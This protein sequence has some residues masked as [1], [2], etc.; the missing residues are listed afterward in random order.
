MFTLTINGI[1]VKAEEGMTV[2]EAADEAG[3]Y[4]PTLCH[5]EDLSTFG[6]CR[7]CM[8]EADDRLVTACRAPVEDGMVVR[9]D[10]PQIRQIRLNNVELILANHNEDCQT[11]DRSSNCQLQKVAAF[12]GVTSDR[13]KD[14]RRFVTDEPVDDSNPFFYRDH[15]K[16]I[17]CGVCIRTCEEINGIAALDF[18][19][20]GYGTSVSVLGDK[21][22]HESNCESCGECVER[23]PT[24]ALNATEQ[25]IPE[26]EVD[27]VCPYCGVGCGITVGVRGEEVVSVRGTRDNPV[28]S[29]ELC[30][31]GRYGFG[32]INHPDRLRSPLIKKDGEFEEVSWDE[33]LDLVASKLDGYKEKYGADSLAGISSARCTNEE[34][35]LFQKL[36]RAV[37][38]NNVDH[39]ARLCHAP[40]VAGL[41]STFGSG[42]MT[43]SIADIEEAEAFFVIGSNTTETH[44]VIGYRVRRAVKKG[45][46][47]I[48]ADPRSIQLA[49]M[50]DIHLQLRPGTNA[51]LLVGLAKVIVEE[52][53]YDEGF[54]QERCEG[55]AD[56]VETLDSVCLSDMAEIT[57]VPE[58]KIRQAARIYAQSNPSTILY[59]MGI[60]QHSHGTDNVL[61]LANLAMLT[62]NLGVRGG[63]V[64][65]LRGQNNVQ[66]ACDMAALPN[67]LPG[68][69]PVTS[70][71]SRQK[72]ADAYGVQL[73]GTP[74]LT[75][76]EIF[77][78]AGAGE[79]KGLYIM[80]ENPIMSE[81]DAGEVEQDLKNTEFLVVQDIFLTETAAHA[82]VV[83]PAA[84]FAEK[85]GS[86]VNTERRIQKIRKA[87]NPP[88]DSRDDADIICDLANRMGLDGFSYEGPEDV[89]VEIASLVPSWKGVSHDR[90]NEGG[91]CWP[92]TSDEHPGTPILYTDSFLREGGKARFASVAYEPPQESV[93]DDYPFILTT[94]RILYHF[95]TSTMTRRST[96]L[97]TLRDREKVM[98][99]PVDAENLGLVEGDEV[100]ITSRRGAVTAE[101]EPTEQM[102]QGTVFM[103]FHFAEACANILT[104][105]ALDPV[106]KIP[107][108]KV[109][110]VRVE[111]V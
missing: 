90:L 78:A 19:F 103:T 18:A 109:C 80:G 73:S 96:G 21:P 88:G 37:G 44:P 81:A 26:Y 100:R 40:T 1:E 97:S 39:C 63:G 22:I 58:D 16:C 71:E 38:T 72:F 31:K 56:Y 99:N 64:N 20:R 25:Y 107:E 62:G 2:F 17:L 95:H 15:T 89:V 48:V 75:M 74:G 28:N 10:S 23:C 86:F 65:P 50:A 76:T 82:D 35:Y 77:A 67:V 24:G 14:M 102:G 29:G 46:P 93:D 9:T 70:E 105:S 4:I 91:L 110:A 5:H 108:L 79:L 42:A 92:C 57:G 36:F 12:V 8:V 106:S 47:L 61:A 45:V 13:M 111:A 43:N 11:C 34:N 52:D 84:C 83:L 101:V 6:G 104:N 33:A 98:M 32:F 85:N 68:Y 55:F 30:V 27:T 59:A 66:G 54:V 60:T 69:Q 41:A 53:L 7:V 3:I 51:A 49:E 94:G 87:I